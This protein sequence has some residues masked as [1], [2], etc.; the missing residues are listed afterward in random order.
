M[1]KTTRSR[2]RRS[3]RKPSGK[4]RRSRSRSKR[5]PSGKPRRSH[6][7]SKRRTQ[8]R[9]DGRDQYEDA[10][11]SRES[12]LQYLWPDHLF[13]AI[14][15]ARDWKWNG[16]AGGSSAEAISIDL[17]EDRGYINANPGRSG[18]LQKKEL[19]TRR[20]E[21]LVSAGNLREWV[22]KEMLDLWEAHMKV[23]N[24]RKWGPRYES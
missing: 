4:P 18:N 20:F 14:W 9:R 16:P 10:Q 12:S 19:F 8:T 13:A 11:D 5:K 3:K 15:L 7:R 17:G 6:S 2:S 21:E 1:A 24:W 22:N 23:R